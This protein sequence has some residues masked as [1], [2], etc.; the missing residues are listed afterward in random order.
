MA[1]AGRKS[2]RVRRAGGREAWRAL[3][4]EGV[5]G[6]AVQPGMTGGA[7]KPLSDHDIHRILETALDILENIGIG[8]PI[9]EIMHYALP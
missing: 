9:P 7:Y 8:E 5:R 3:R 6:Q 1:E 2:R 4:A